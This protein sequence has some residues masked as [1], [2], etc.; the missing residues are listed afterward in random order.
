MIRAVSLPISTNLLSFSKLLRTRGLAHRINEESGEQVLWVASEADAELVRSEL[1]QWLKQE[2]TGVS[3]SEDVLPS[4]LN[5]SHSAKNFANGVVAAVYFYPV[6]AALFTICVI[7]AIV[8]GLGASPNS[9]G[10]LFYPYVASDGLLLLISELNSPLKLL[11]TL[12]PIFLH[13]GELHLV[14]NM[15]WLWYFGRQLESL[16]SKS[17]FIGL[18]LVTAFVSNTTQ[19]MLNDANNFGGMSGVVYGL[20]GYSWVIHK[21]MPKSYIVLSPN[22]MTFFVVALVAMEVLASS[23]VATGAHIGGLLAGLVLGAVAVLINRVLLK[24]E[25]VGSQPPNR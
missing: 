4:S 13:F 10:L 7:V 2:A 18:V 24:K 25:A 3:T 5:V 21:L 20:V 1:S 12:T 19:Y 14:F 17:S 6:T 11:Q 9:V 8:S 22:M 15:L 23:M 16:H